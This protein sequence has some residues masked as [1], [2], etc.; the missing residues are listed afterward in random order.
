VYIKVPR[1]GEK[2]HLIEMVAQNALIALNQF[3]DRVK[4]E[5]ALKKEGL[6]SLT[7]LLELEELPLRIEAYDISNTGSSEIVASM[8]V[9]EDGAPANK[10]YRK[11]RIKSVE[12]QNDYQSTAGVIYRRFKHAERERNEIPPNGLKILKDARPVVD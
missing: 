2:L 1:K 12:K 7:G 10:E 3:I 8:I 11:F 9:F 4:K 5:E 6:R